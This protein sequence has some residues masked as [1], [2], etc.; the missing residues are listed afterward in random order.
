MNQE[1]LMINVSRL[2]HSQQVKGKGTAFTVIKDIGVMN[3]KNSQMFKV[4]RS[5]LV[6]DVIYV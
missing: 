4:G 5:R 2:L 3:V 6:E 1:N